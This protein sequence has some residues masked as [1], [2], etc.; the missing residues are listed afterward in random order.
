MRNRAEPALRYIRGTASAFPARA[1][2]SLARI[3]AGRDLVNGLARQFD[4]EQDAVELMSPGR[5]GRGQVISPP[6]PMMPP[7]M[8]APPSTS[9]RIAIAAVCQSL[10]TRP[11]NMV[12]LA[13]SAIKVEWLRVA[14]NVGGESEGD[15][16]PPCRSLDV[17]WDALPKP[18]KG[19]L[20][21]PCWSRHAKDHVTRPCEPVGRSEN[22]LS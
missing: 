12:R 4:I 18:D 14:G 11:P 21:S 5:L 17:G 16:V 2:R 1:R 22:P 9:R 3:S 7:A 6:A 10:A 13:I 19:G 8:G 15:A 20:F